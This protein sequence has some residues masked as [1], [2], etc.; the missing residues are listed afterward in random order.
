MVLGEVAVLGKLEEALQVL[1]NLKNPIQEGVSVLNVLNFCRGL[2]L[3]LRLC[4]KNLR[5]EKKEMMEERESLNL[6]P[7]NYDYNIVV[8]MESIIFLQ[9]KRD[10]LRRVGRAVDRDVVI[11]SSSLRLPLNKV[12]T[13]SD[14]CNQHDKVLC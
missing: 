9:V 12:T 5:L 14:S 3:S 7:K 13:S 1:N 4:V 2:P 11:A 8:L 6:L 10:L